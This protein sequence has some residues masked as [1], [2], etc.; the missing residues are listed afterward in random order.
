MNEVFRSAPWPGP[1][2]HADLPVCRGRG[3]HRWGGLVRRRARTWAQEYRK[4]GGEALE[5]DPVG[6][7]AGLARIKQRQTDF[8]A[9]D[10]MVPR[11]ELARDGLVMFPT[12]VS[13]IVPVVDL[14]KGGRRSS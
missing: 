6:S 8:G 4:A 11:N 5:Y 14:R 1:G 9:V 2:R 10:V 7:G 12:A 13:G 3:R